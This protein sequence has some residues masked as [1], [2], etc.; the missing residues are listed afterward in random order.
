[1]TLRW[2]LLD[3]TIQ[4]PPVYIHPPDD[5][6]YY[7]REY[8]SKGGFT[9]SDANQLISN[10]KKPTGRRGKPEWRY[11]EAAVR[12]FAEELSSLLGAGWLVSFIPTSKLKTDPEYDS[13]FEDT[14]GHLSQLRPDLRTGEVIHLREAMDPF[15]TSGAGTRHPDRFYEKIGWTGLP[16]EITGVVLIDDLLTSGSHFIACK[17]LILERKPGVQVIGAFW[18]KTIWQ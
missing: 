5:R 11:K 16:D 7:A 8:I 10:F 3:E 9:S 2:L 17:R 14:L 1:M 4:D 12:K 13:R 15:H 6:C 18:A